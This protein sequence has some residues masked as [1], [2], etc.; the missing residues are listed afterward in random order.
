MTILPGVFC[1]VY[2]PCMPGFTGVTCRIVHHL[3]LLC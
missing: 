3:P 2:V 1:L